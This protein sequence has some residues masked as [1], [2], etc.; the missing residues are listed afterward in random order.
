MCNSVI[1]K[2]HVHMAIG[3]DNPVSHTP[4]CNTWNFFVFGLEQIRKL[5]VILRYLDN[6]EHY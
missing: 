2:R 4:D 6:L 3:M 1:D 5:I